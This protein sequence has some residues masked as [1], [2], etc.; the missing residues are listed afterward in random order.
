MRLYDWLVEQ[1]A[2]DRYRGQERAAGRRENRAKESIDRR[3]DAL[4]GR[5]SRA[6]QARERID[7]RVA[8]LRKQKQELH[9]MED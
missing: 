1:G 6:V 8:K 9:K 5:I 3:K 2:V 4:R 7:Q